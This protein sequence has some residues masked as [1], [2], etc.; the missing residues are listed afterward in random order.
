MSFCSIPVALALLPA[1]SC[2]PMTTDE[3]QGAMRDRGTTLSRWA[4]AH[5]WNRATVWKVSKGLVDGPQGRKIRRALNAF[6]AKPVP[7]AETLPEEM[8]PHETVSRTE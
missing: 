3:I 6:L 4:V 7:P 2:P 8:M 1:V 5:R